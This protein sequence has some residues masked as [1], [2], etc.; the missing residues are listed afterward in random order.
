M[1]R[2][3][4]SRASKVWER[5][6]QWYGARMADSYG[7]TPP[8]DCAELIDRTDD[9]RLWDA[10]FAVRKETP[11]FPPTLGQLEAALPRRNLDA[12]RQPSKA[13]TLCELML[14]THGM[15]MCMHQH[16]RPWNYFGPVSEF[17]VANKQS[18]SHADPRGAQVPACEAC[19][20]PSYRVTLDEAV[21]PGVAA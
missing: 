9:V 1:P 11:I 12:D 15:Q 5:L 20:R 6:G 16:A 17:A 14:K 21:G 4:S 18:V 8:D 10:L 2:K 13:Q 7:P 3:I 19:G